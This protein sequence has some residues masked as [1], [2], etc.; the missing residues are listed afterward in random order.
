[1]KKITEKELI[2]AAKQSGFTD[3]EY[4]L[5]YGKSSFDEKIG[6]EEYAI[7]DKLVK[8]LSKFDIEVVKDFDKLKK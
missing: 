2:E 8:L 6:I 7:G 5:Y 4:G 1:M 3:K